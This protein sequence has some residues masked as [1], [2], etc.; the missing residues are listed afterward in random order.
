MTTSKHKI[1]LL[2]GSF[3]PIH[4]A[5][6]RLA[7]T[8]LQQLSLDEVQLI[9]AGQPWQKAPLA[10]SSEQR[11]AMLKIA[12]KGI[13]GL[14]INTI[15]LERKGPSYTID[16]LRELP[17]QSGERYY[18]L[19]GTD[20]INNFCT[21]RAWQEILDYVQLVVAK[22]PDY[23]FTPP[24]ELLTV[25]QQKGCNLIFLNMPEIDLSSTAV[26]QKLLDHAPVDNL[27][28]PAV[29]AYIQAHKLYY[30]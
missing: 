4:L 12:I 15:E 16:T 14:R 24:V 28:N 9:P 27:L 30:D 20:Q 26:R 18:W 6:I 21:W 22:R 2:G 3:N 29:L 25:L 8:A 23:A 7:T 17:R 1:G 19:M 5:H 11:L 10:V 13:A